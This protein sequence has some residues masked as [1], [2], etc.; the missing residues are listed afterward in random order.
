VTRY[1][2]EDLVSKKSPSII[3]ETDDSVPLYKEGS[4]QKT[5]ANIKR[6][7]RNNAHKLIEEFMVLANEEVAKWCKKHD[8]PFLSR[9]HGLPGNEQT[10]I[11]NT[12]LAQTQK[13]QQLIKLPTPK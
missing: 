9:V 13:D 11:I 1:E 5:P 2:G 8:L 3:T 6:R 10:E 4:T 7:E 12:I